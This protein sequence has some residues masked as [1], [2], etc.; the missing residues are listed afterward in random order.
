MTLRGPT[1]EATISDQPHP[2][3]ST[4]GARPLS[5]NVRLWLPKPLHIQPKHPVIKDFPNIRVI[6]YPVNSG[7]PVQ[8]LSEKYSFQ[9]EGF[10]SRRQTAET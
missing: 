4:H 2:F 5:R 1:P 10:G 3:L 9:R 6:R 8:N 7:A